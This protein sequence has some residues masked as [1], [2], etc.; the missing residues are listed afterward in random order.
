MDMITP[1]KIQSCKYNAPIEAYSV[2]D[3]FMEYHSWHTELY[4]QKWNGHVE[5]TLYNREK[6]RNKI[7]NSLK[8]PYVS[9]FISMI[10][11]TCPMNS[12]RR[13]LEISIIIR[14]GSRVAENASTSRG[15]SVKYYNTK[16]ISMDKKIKDTFEFKDGITKIKSAFGRTLK[17]KDFKKK[18]NP[19]KSSDDKNQGGKNV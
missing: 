17:L 16:E 8:I 9:S 1:G 3:L 7:R 12:S 2:F 19:S 18:T 10:S 4:G 5:D 13:H 14:S 6:I 15:K 11:S